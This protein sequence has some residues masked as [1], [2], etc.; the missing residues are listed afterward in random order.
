[1]V[2]NNSINLNGVTPDFR[3]YVNTPVVNVIG[4]GASYNVIFNTVLYDSTS[5]YNNATGVFSAPVDGIFFFY[6][7][8]T[9]TN[10]AGHTDMLCNIRVIGG[11]GS[12]IYFNPSA[13]AAGGILNISV[14]CIAQLVIGDM[15]NC[16]VIANSTKTVGVDG[17]ANASKSS[18]GG[19]LVA[20]I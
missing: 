16:D 5:S 14:S 20:L 19:Y 2:T 18:F 15:V 17:A 12:R 1:M 10:I 13:F 4:A 6:N 8:V 7:N 9:L 3:A 11:A